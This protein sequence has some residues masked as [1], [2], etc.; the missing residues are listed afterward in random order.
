MELPVPADGGQQ[1]TQRD[2]ARPANRDADG[3]V[4]IVGRGQHVV[5]EGQRE[6]VRVLVNQRS[7]CIDVHGLPLTP[8]PARCAWREAGSPG[9]EYR[10]QTGLQCAPG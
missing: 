3:V 7:V 1:L 2:Q 10:L 9:H 4:L 6:A 8:A 5:I